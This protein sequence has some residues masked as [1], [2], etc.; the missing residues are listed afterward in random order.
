MKKGA[1]YIGK[2]NYAKAIKEFDQ[3]IEKFCEY[4]SAYDYRCYCN[5]KLGN[6]EEAVSDLVRAL[7][8]GKEREK[9]GELFSVISQSCNSLLVQELL[10]ECEINPYNRNLFYFLGLAFQ[11]GRKEKEAAEAFAESAKE[12]E[13]LKG[14][15]I[16]SG[17]HFQGSNGNEF[18]K[19]L[20]S[21]MTYPEIAK[22][23]ELDG[24]VTCSFWIDEDGSVSDVRVINEV[25]YDLDSQLVKAIGN[26]PLWTPAMSLGKPVKSLY[27]FTMNYI[28]L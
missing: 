3:V 16:T 13:G 8:T 21:R 22:A 5:I 24:A 11:D 4:G 23:N 2:G 25:H 26:S 27:R 10:K 20:R 19:W 15:K 28:I 1:A 18:G 6:T 14:L 7:R 9:T 12:F 17:A